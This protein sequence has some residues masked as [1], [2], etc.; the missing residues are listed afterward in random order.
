MHPSSSSPSTPD[1]R[2][3]RSPRAW[4]GLG[5]ALGLPLVY[6]GLQL[7]ARTADPMERRAGWLERPADVET[8]GRLSVR[9]Y[10]R[11]GWGEAGGDTFAVLAMDGEPLAVAGGHLAAAGLCGACDARV[12]EAAVAFVR[13]REEAQAGLFVVQLVDGAARWT[14]LCGGDHPQRRW[15]GTRYSEP[16]CGV[17]YDAATRGIVAAPTPPAAAEPTR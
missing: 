10:E 7:P 12:G 14:R 17:S 3:R 15:E 1:P 13:H 16:D 4:V 8:V 6:L 5:L 2:P 11:Q 9:S